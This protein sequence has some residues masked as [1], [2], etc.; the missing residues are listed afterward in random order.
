M[1]SHGSF[2]PRWSMV[3]QHKLVSAHQKTYQVKAS[4]W[5]QISGDNPVVVLGPCM[6]CGVRLAKIMFALLLVVEMEMEIR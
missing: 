4:R 3:S 5:I 2:P 6:F 1:L